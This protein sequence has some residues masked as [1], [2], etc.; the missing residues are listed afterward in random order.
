MTRIKATFLTAAAL[1]LI[2]P[3]GCAQTWRVQSSPDKSFS[4]ELPAPLSK[5]KSFDGE[6][7]IDFSPEQDGRGITSYAAIETNPDDCRFGIVIIGRKI[8]ERYLRLGPR[9]EI[10][11]YLGALLIGNEDEG[12][13]TSVKEITINGLKGRDYI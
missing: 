10:F 6:H 2:P 7:G 4:V 1:L 3:H 11:E 5:V 13:P 9:D 12:E 8:R